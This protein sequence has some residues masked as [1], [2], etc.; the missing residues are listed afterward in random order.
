M[1]AF[2][3]KWNDARAMKR[4]TRLAERGVEHSARF[5]RDEAK[6]L[7]S[8]PGPPRSKAGPIGGNSGEP[9]RVDEGD[10]IASVVATSA[11][12]INGE[13]LAWAGTPIDYGRFL[14]YGWVHNVFGRAIILQGPRPWMRPAYA[15]LLA[16]WPKFFK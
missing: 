12:T 15:Q 1:A 8:I 7:I 11:E 4:M 6:Q 13:I 16:N 14:E 2:T 9:P 10:L 5:V 3:L